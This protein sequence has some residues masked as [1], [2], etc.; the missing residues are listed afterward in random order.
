MNDVVFDI[1]WTRVRLPP[2]PTEHRS[3][4]MSEKTWTT[5]GYFKEFNNAKEKINELGEEYEL[6]KIKRVRERTKEGMFKLKAWKQPQEQLKSKKKKK[7][8]NKDHDN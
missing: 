5:C 4:N 3:L 2:L 1:F 8:A 6:Y 7:N